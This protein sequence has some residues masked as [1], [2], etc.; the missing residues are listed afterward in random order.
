MV[1][2]K[3]VVYA[4]QRRR[5]GTYNVK[6]R[7]THKGVHRHLATS[8]YCTQSELTRSLAIKDHEVQRK[9]DAV[10]AQLR[11][12][13][14]RI[15]M[16][17]I[18]VHDVDWVVA[19]L[20]RIIL[21]SRPFR[22]DFFQFANEALPQFKDQTRYI[23]GA[24]VK[25]FHRW[26]GHDLDVNAITYEMLHDYVSWMQ[27]EGKT[28]AAFQVKCLRRIFS[29]ACEKYNDEDSGVV[30][31]PRQPFSRLKV[32]STSTHAQ[33]ALPETVIQMM[34]DDTTD[35][36]LIRRALDVFLLSFCLMGANVADLWEAAPPDGGVWTYERVKTRDARA[37]RAH[38]EVRIPPEA[39]PYI[40]RLRGR[41]HWLNLSEEWSLKKYLI[42]SVW[43][44]LQ[45]WARLHEVEPFSVYAARHSWATI[46]RRAGVEK[47]LVDECLAHKGD[48]D[49]ADVYAERN[50][51]LMAEANRKV[52]DR[53]RWDKK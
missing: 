44:G 36:P 33:K 46:A 2:F 17:E 4:H 8:I 32:R 52:L 12:A 20:R 1:T 16:F 41:R 22:L 28:S 53:F 40:E 29:L 7:V 26:V 42:R 50:W 6:V 10:L 31:I 21:S 14:S 13:L 19:E 34:I 43:E 45:K 23:Y 11:S 9:A 48:F 25:A 39:E 37:D 35:R 38:M 30:R 5:D 51:Q 15:S 27:R 3:A 49:M 18:E 24:A 47:A